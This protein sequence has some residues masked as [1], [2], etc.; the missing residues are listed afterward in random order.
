MKVK[1]FRGKGC[2]ELHKDV[3]LKKQMKWNLNNA[4]TLIVPIVVSVLK[5]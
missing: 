3:I 2:R 1:F 4:D 5:I